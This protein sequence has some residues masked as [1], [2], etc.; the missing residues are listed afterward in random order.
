MHPIF[1]LIARKGAEGAKD[2]LFDLLLNV[3]DIHLFANNGSSTGLI[4]AECGHFSNTILAF[5]I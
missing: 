2:D 4:R 5:K 1:V 3:N